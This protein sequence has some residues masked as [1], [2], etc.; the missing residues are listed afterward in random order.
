[1]LI[2]Y[3]LKNCISITI[4]NTF[5][6]H[7]IKFNWSVAWISYSKW[8][9]VLY[10]HLKIR[11]LILM[12]FSI[13][14]I[15]FNESFLQTNKNYELQLVQFH[16]ILI[17]RGHVSFWYSPCTS[18]EI[19]WLKNF[20]IA[21]RNT[22]YQKYTYSQHNPVVYP[23]WTLVAKQQE[24]PPLGKLRLCEWACQRELLL[25]FLCS[26]EVS[27]TNECKH[28]CNFQLRSSAKLSC[29]LPHAPLKPWLSWWFFFW[30]LVWVIAGVV[31]FGI[32]STSNAIEIAR[33]KAECYFN[34]FTSA[35][36]P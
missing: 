1:M 3:F 6:L 28:S 9:C 19:N 26:L 34:C 13:K 31:L 35:I 2:L 17:I 24:S 20:E 10:I 33:G 5:E 8:F 36:D 29:F 21:L 12:K 18:L 14:N 23:H 4:T 7:H 27:V 22:K 16:L 30:Q 15:T 11:S 32:N 25:L